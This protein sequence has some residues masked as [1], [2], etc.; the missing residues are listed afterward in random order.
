MCG[1]RRRT[2][3]PLATRLCAEALTRAH[4]FLGTHAQRGRFRP[5]REWCVDRTRETLG[6]RHRATQLAVGGAHWGPRSS[7]RGLVLRAQSLSARERH[8]S[9]MIDRSSDFSLCLFRVCRRNTGC[10]GPAFP[11]ALRTT[12][13]TCPY[14]G[15]RQSRCIHAPVVRSG[16]RVARWPQGAVSRSRGQ[17]EIGEGCVGACV[18]AIPCGQVR[19]PG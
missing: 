3:P 7:T 2:T 18:R 9:R 12:G 5:P 14:L 10:N 6:S 13:S 1:C 17:R 4:R 8:R 15:D 16:A 19:P 11:T